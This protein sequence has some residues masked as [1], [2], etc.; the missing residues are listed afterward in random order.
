M[1]DPWD[2]LGWSAAEVEVVEA[3]VQDLTTVFFLTGLGVLLLLAL[4]GR[5]SPVARRHFW[6]ALAERDVEVE[7]QT[8]GL[9][10]FPRLAVVRRCSAFDPPTAVACDQR[11]L[12][13]GFRRQWAPPLPVAERKSA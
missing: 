12:D 9:L 11:C 2:V 3:A 1:V 10:P 4:A 7:F 8:R 6:C 13:P 5:F